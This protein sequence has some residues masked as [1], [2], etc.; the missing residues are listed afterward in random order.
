MIKKIFKISVISLVLLTIAC[1]DMGEPEILLPQIEVE[2]S[3]VDYS[4][5]TIGT[6]Q[7]REFY[8]ANLGV[9]DLSGEISLIQD[10]S[11]FAFQ[12]EA[13]FI[14]SEDDTLFGE[15]SF[16]P[17]SAS[18]YTAE[19]LI[20]SD[21]PD[22]P[23][24][25]IQVTGSGT[26]E[27]LP[28]IAFSSNQISFGTIASDAFAQQT[29]TIFN[30][31]TDTLDISALSTDLSEFQIDVA[32]PFALIPADSQNVVV[33]FTP[34]LAGS[35]NAQMTIV[36]NSSSSPHQIAISGV[37]EDIVGYASQVQPIWNANCTA[38]HGSNGGLTL[39]SYAQLMSGS[40][41]GATVIPNNAAGSLIIKRLRG[42]S[43]TQMPQGGT[44]LSE[45]T[46]SLVETWIN[47]GAQ[48]N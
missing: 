18:D 48:D 47:Q 38:C 4:T 9:G 41:S 45:A 16:T 36:S 8:I 11:V 25:T 12:P 37:A 35:F 24:L 46:I 23:E 30:T 29:F 2:V 20:A 31:G 21:D 42:T 39:S 40:N 1:T 43:G 27:L 22:S 28:V 13:A 7:S 14:L 5:Q 10:S 33:T 19:L 44:P 26:A 15:L 34:G 32:A 17:M 3:S 6:T